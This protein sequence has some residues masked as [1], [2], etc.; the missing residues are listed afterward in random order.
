[1]H[2]ELLVHELQC[3]RHLSKDRHRVHRLQR[4]QVSQVVCAVLHDNTNL[5]TCIRTHQ[6]PTVELHYVG[7]LALRKSLH[8]SSERFEGILFREAGDLDSTHHLVSNSVSDRRGLLPLNNDSPHKLEGPLE[9]PTIATE[10]HT[11]GIL[12]VKLYRAPL[13]LTQSGRLREVEYRSIGEGL[14][15]RGHLQLDLS[16]YFIQCSI[17]NAPTTALAVVRCRSCLRGIRCSMLM[18]VVQCVQQLGPRSSVQ[19]ASLQCKGSNIEIE[20]FDAELQAS[21]AFSEVALLA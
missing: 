15:V 18:L 6:Y 8:F 20:L 2:D 16:H 3:V 14:A 1:M 12:L 7:V 9:H 11:R 19:M 5:T 4:P 17:A 10:R 13:E 21:S